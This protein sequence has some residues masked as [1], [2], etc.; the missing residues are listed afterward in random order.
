LSE[1][2]AGYSEKSLAEKLGIKSGFTVAL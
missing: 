1:R 2:V